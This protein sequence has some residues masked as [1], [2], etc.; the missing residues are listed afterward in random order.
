GPPEGPADAR[1]R[2]DTGCSSVRHEINHHF[3]SLQG[4][5]PTQSRCRKAEAIFWI[6]AAARGRLA[7]TV[8]RW[9][10][11]DFWRLVLH[12]RD[13]RKHVNLIAVL[14]R[15]FQ[16]G[17]RPIA[18]NAEV[19][20]DARRLIAK[21][22]AHTGPAGVKDGNH[23]GD[24]FGRDFHFRYGVWKKSEQRPRK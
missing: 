23:I 2:I 14:E 4:R 19:P 9:K 8:L 22:V 21:P 15:R 1:A 5:S 6:A 7:M 11:Q 24:R 10:H 13:V 16:G 3:P 12:A 18:E 17:A 20:P